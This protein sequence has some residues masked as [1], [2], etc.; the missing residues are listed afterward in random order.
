VRFLRA[1]SFAFR[2]ALLV[3]VLLAANACGDLANV[4]NSPARRSPAGVES[5]FGAWTKVAVWQMNEGPNATRMHDSSGNGRSGTIGSEVE[6]SVTVSGETGYRWSA[7]NG[8]VVDPERLVMV[9][10][11]ALNPGRD[12]FAVTIRLK[13]SVTGNH[14]IIQKGQT[15]TAGGMW[16]I[17]MLNGR[18]FCTYTGAAG[19]VA[20][21][22]R[23]TVSD[24]VWH[25]VSC[26]RRRTGVTISVDGGLPRAQAGRTGRIANPW[27]LAIGGKPK[28]N[29]ATTMCHYYVGLLD[30]VIVRR[31]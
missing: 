30:R 2:W 3:A 25:T 10:S 1:S 23:Q 27:P 15:G 29:Q 17:D 7:V 21:G 18:I 24:D 20:I 11:S 26:E 6:T 9:N 8:D 13:T 5:A 28:C 14:N 12:A 22:S 19:R 16:K 31:R 4:P